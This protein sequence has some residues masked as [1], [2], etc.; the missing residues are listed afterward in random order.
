MTVDA[1]GGLVTHA[2]FLLSPQGASECRLRL[3]QGQ[4]LVL[5]EVDGVK[6]ILSRDTATDWRVTLLDQ[7]TPQGVSLVT[8]QETPLTAGDQVLLPQVLSHDSHAITPTDSLTAVRD[9]PSLRFVLPATS[10]SI[11]QAARDSLWLRKLAAASPASVDKIEKNHWWASRLQDALERVKGASIAWQGDDD[12]ATVATSVPAAIAFA[13]TIAQQERPYHADGTE[14]LMQEAMGNEP[15]RSVRN[16]AEQP[17]EIRLVRRGS[18]DWPARLGL[19]LLA[20]GSA[21]VF[22]KT[23]GHDGAAALKNYRNTAIA[24]TGLGWWLL[25]PL[26]FGGLLMMLLAAVAEVRERR[27]RTSPEG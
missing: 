6:P 13:K 17:G 2:R 16:T 21:V 1:A 23:R 26:G 5:L 15:W 4:R 3:P 19:S 12:L 7:Q 14:V 11:G 27:C 22:W 25:L 8:V 18:Y 9:G 20:L 10:H 24:L